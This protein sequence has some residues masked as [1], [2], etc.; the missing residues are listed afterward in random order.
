MTSTAAQTNEV[1][2]E[3]AYKKVTLHLLPFIFICYLFNYFDRVNVGFAKLQMLDDL[4]L[5]ETV[6]GLG[7]GIF[8]VGYVLFGVPSNLMLRKVGARRW[9]A[10][11]MM[12]W[13][14]L[15]ASLMLVKSPTSFYVLR[16]LTGVAEAGFF[17]GIV[18]YFTHW[19]P[20]ARRGRIMA[21]FMSAIPVSG[22]LGG[23]FSGWILDHFAQGQGGLAGWQWLYLL[24]GIPTVLLGVAVLFCLNDGI[25]QAR[26]LDEREQTLLLA[27][28]AEDEQNKPKGAADSFASVLRNPAVW[29]LGM[30]YFCIQ[31]GV[32][33]IN[34]WLP[35]I[36]KTLGFQNAQ[37]IGWL[38]AIP[39]LIAGIFMVLVGRSADKHHERRWH[40]MV[41]MLMGMTGLIVAANFAH[42]PL[43][44]MLGLTLATMGALTGLPMF[45]PLPAGY[46][47][48]AAA[49]GGLALINSLGQMA[50]FLS[51]YLVGWI[52]DAT[53]ST[54][55]ALYILA[56]VMLLGV[57]LVSR[58]PAA[59]VNR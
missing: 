23:P 32:Y 11:L 55:L 17:P 7:A 40:V 56:G 22:L 9:I 35:S 12:L 50:G 44:A 19:F 6:Y 43:I 25:K 59:T 27:A 36:I 18:L 46:L 3:Q 2:L 42:S 49:A 41:P 54:D 31:S 52:K 47:S 24:Q 51:P 1:V 34:F 5:S 38:S 37:V 53:H 45:W 33:A 39:Y 58:I 57:L 28:L 14:S 10:V 21:L 16:F 4:H 48:A 8:F 26:W 30:I 20:S 29:M 15:S 13:G